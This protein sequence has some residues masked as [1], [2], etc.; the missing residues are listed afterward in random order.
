M[1]STLLPDES[2]PLRKTD[3]G[4]SAG[5]CPKLQSCGH[6]QQHLASPRVCSRAGVPKFINEVIYPIRE[7]CLKF[8]EAVGPA[9]DSKVGCCRDEAVVKRLAHG[10]VPAVGQ[11]VACAWLW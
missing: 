8:R 3:R 5:L 4:F 7:I 1:F 6:G 11:G 9:E 10:S 2:C